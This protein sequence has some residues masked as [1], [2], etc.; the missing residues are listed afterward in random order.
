LISDVIIKA[1]NWH[2]QCRDYAGTT[3]NFGAHLELLIPCPA[4]KGKGLLPI[5]KGSILNS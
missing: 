1:Q 4:L 3:G 2:P 5:L